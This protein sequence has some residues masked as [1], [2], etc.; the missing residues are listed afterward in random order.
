MGDVPVVRVAGPSERRR[1][2]GCIGSPSCH[3][4]VPALRTSRWSASVVPSASAV[5]AASDRVMT[6][7]MGDRQMLPVQ[8]KTMR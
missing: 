2:S 8:T 4:P 5:D 7:A 1:A 6:S 3:G